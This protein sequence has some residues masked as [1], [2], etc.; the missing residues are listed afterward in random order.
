MKI[1]VFLIL[2][3]IRY[4]ASDQQNIDDAVEIFPKSS[5]QRK[6]LAIE[7]LARG[8]TCMIKF[9]CS[10]FTCVRKSNKSYSFMFLE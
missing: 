10:Y 1:F 8:V 6:L 4:I 3:F 5:V 2:D 9:S 7:M